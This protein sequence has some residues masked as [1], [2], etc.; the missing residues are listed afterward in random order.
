[1]NKKKQY[2]KKYYQEHADEIKA[3]K[4]E[5]RQRPEIKAKQ[6]ES[7]EKRIKFLK[8]PLSERQKIIRKRYG[9]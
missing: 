3:K 9:K 1:M 6:K 2:F 4:K 8:L 5:Y 7:K